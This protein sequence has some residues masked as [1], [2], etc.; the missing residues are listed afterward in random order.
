M[1]RRGNVIDM[2]D[3]IRTS[4]EL[5]EIAHLYPL[6]YSQKR[7]HEWV[8]LFDSRAVAIRVQE[9][10]TTSVLHVHAALPEQEEYA[11]ENGTLLETWDNIEIRQFGNIAT[12]KADYVLVAERETRKGIDLLTLTNDA[13]G[14]RIVALAYEQT[15]LISR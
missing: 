11:Q 3:A 6:L 7:L 2:H 15:Q 13:G 9:G 8:Q 4:L 14:W 10:A 5:E 12:I 1:H